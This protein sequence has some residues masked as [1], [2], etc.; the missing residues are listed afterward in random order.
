MRKVAVTGG[1]A[2]GKSTVCSLFKE[3]GAYVVS[4]DQIVHQLLSPDTHLGKKIIS[5][6]GPDIIKNEQFDRNEMAKIAFQNEQS[7]HGLESLIHPEV[8]KE[9]DSE[10]IKAKA[11]RAPLFVAEV[12]LL[13]E[14]GGEKFF[15]ETIAVLANEEL[16][17]QRS[18]LDPDD[19]AKRM[20]RQLTMEEKKAKADFFIVNEGNLASLKEQ[21]KHIFNQLV[22]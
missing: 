14:T 17:L 19:F 20:K 2:S 22:G 13:F 21:V 5:L 16:C 12:P 11:Q 9:I 1:L 4:S 6:L 15:D 18:Q 3:L 10:Y 8:W 7:L